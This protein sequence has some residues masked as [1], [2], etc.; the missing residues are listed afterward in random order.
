[1]TRIA[2]AGVANVALG[3]EAITESDVQAA[4]EAYENGVS[5]NTATGRAYKPAV[6]IFK[7]LRNEMHAEGIIEAGPIPGFLIECL[8]W[9]VPN[10]C[11]THDTWSEDIESVLLSIWASTMNDQIS[12]DLLEVN[13][14]KYLFRPQQK[15]TREHAHAFANAAQH[16]LGQI[17]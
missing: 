13:G 10:N 5:K 7:S 4:L 9:N 1:M 17:R 6:R 15:W 12:H 14:I 8:V 2:I 11:F 16:H 3:D